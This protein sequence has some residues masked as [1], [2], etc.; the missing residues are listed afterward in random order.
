M[1]T[2]FS[3]AELHSRSPGAPQ[4]FCP[5]I[6]PFA[7]GLL[8]WSEVF[9]QHLDTLWEK[10]KRIQMVCSPW[11]VSPE[12][13]LVVTEAEGSTSSSVSNLDALRC[14]QVVPGVLRV[15]LN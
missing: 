9:I 8:P 6:D 5:E 4:A 11:V 13:A 14:V 15:L 2:I 10:L 12:L 7:D 3:E 1:F